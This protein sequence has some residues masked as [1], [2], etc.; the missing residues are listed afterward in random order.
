MKNRPPAESVHL[1]TR[2]PLAAAAR[3]RR[4]RGFTLLELMIAVAA[5]AILT[6]IGVSSFRW[7]TNTNRVATEVNGLLGDM[8]F[9]RGEAIKEGQTVTICT[10]NNGTSCAGTLTWHSGWIVFS[11]ANGNKVVDAGEPVRRWQKSLAPGDTFTAPATISAVTFSREGFALGLPGTVLITLHD[12]TT[13][14]QSVR[15]LQLTIVGQM[16]ILKHGTLGCV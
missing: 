8:Q 7:V 14:Q 10:S 16:Q 12:A 9:A 1:G 2:P 5:V 6:G 11:D 15:C 4:A 13:S 3:H